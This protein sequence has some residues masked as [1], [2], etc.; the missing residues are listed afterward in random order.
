MANSDHLSVLSKGVKY[1]N[2]WRESNPNIYPDL[3]NSSIVGRPLRNINFK[4]TDLKHADLRFTLLSRADLSNAQLQGADLRGVSLR[5]A[6]LTGADLTNAILRHVTLAECNIHNATFTGSQIYGISAWNLEG[7]PKDQSGLIIRA[8]ETDPLVTVDDLKVAQFIFLLLNHKNLQKVF[9]SVTKKGVLLLGRFGGGGIEILRAIADKLREMN[10]LPIIFDF[11]R[12]LDRTYT[13]TVKI[14]AG[15]SRFVVV[16][17]SGPS[18]P[19]EL[20]ATVPNFKI[21]FVPILEKGKQPYA[22][23]VD[24]LENDWVLKPIIEFDTIN[25]LIKSLPLKIVQPAEK[26]HKKRQKLL[27]ELFAK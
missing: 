3:S 17:L 24:F 5:R 26:K 12:P 15:L 14:L 27:R 13:E 11:E 19:H 1:W 25:N 16:D 23:F 9:N 21:P 10:Y 6:I 4:R 18:V 8:T 22:M 20:Y 2:D 7:K